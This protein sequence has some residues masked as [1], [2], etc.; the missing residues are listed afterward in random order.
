QIETMRGFKIPDALVEQYG[1]PQIT[2]DIR[3]K[4]F[5]LNAA[6]V[7]GIDPAV[8]KCAIDGERTAYEKRDLDD[9]YGPRRWTIQRPFGPTSRG[10]RSGWRAA[11]SSPA[12]W[13]WRP[14]SGP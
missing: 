1:Y 6:K 7:F 5:G 4:I 12:R 13:E 8:R 11:N 10:A 3:A 2:D 14:R 9:Y